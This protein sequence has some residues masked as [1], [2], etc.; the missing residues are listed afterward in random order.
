ML[1][2]LRE[3]LVTILKQKEMTITTME[4]CTSG[5][6]IS[7]I[8]D[9]EGASSI[10]E[11]GYVTYSNKAKIRM[12]VSEKIINT[13]GVY[14]IETAKAMADCCRKLNKANIGVGITGTFSN[15]DPNNKDSVA[16]VVYY[17]ININGIEYTKKIILPILFKNIE[18]T[19]R[20]SQ[21]EFVCITILKHII[22]LI[23]A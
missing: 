14:S 23:S 18:K 22:E 8:T 16:G 11:G 6:L 15:V 9:V 19:Q 1:F 4:S 5:A 7:S 2:D 13:Y 10:T 20:Q 21:K 17:C 3:Q 12:G